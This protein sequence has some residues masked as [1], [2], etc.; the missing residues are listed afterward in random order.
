MNRGKHDPAQRIPALV[1][2][3]ATWQSQSMRSSV[4]ALVPSGALALLVACA[5]QATTPQAG[6]ALFAQNCAVCHGADATGGAQVPDLT[7]LRQRA[8][9]TFPRALVL[10]KLD[11]YARGQAA[12]AGVQMPEFGGLLVGHLSRVP[13]DDGM[14]RPLPEPIIALAAW[15]ETVQR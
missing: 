10:E 2:W 4:L 11:G 12:Y 1:G 3:T 9:G 8:G 15:L 13:T 7:G 5:P 6:R 14:S